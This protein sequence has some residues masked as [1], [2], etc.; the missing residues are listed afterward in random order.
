MFY[1]CIMNK[2]LQSFY[3][4][5]G[6]T[7]TQFADE[8]G[9]QRSSISHVISGRNKPSMDFIEKILRRYPQLNIDW[10]ILGSGPMLKGDDLFSG[11]GKDMKEKKLTA[12][13]SMPEDNDATSRVDSMEVKKE[14]VVESKTQKQED[15]KPDP[16]YEEDRFPTTKDTPSSN[17]ENQIERDVLVSRQASESQRVIIIHAD[18]TYSE[19]LK[20]KD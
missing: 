19:Y 20:R 10:L 17:S 12:S 18:G 4:A 5:L 6:L 8:V 1:I 2:R 11:S 13:K 7:A 9:V 16:L 3:K 14:A 15:V